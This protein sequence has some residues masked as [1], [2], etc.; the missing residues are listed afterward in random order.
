[1]IYIYDI[2]R[3]NRY[4]SCASKRSTSPAPALSRSALARASASSARSRSRSW[5]RTGRGYPQTAKQRRSARRCSD[6]WG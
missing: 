4:P 6:R 5:T 1:M 3:E 2:Y